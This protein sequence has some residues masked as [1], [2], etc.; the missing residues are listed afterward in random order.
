MVWTKFVTTV[1][2]CGVL[3]TVPAGAA[4]L[5]TT[6]RANF[7]TEVTC[8]ALRNAILTTLE[9]DAE[10]SIKQALVR[11][12]VAQ[13]EHTC[14]LADPDAKALV[15]AISNNDLAARRYGNTGSL[16]MTALRPPMPF[17]WYWLHNRGIGPMPSVRDAAELMGT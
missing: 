13:F 11:N 14:T 4:G 10:A 17:L 5:Y 16:P 7:S 3:L 8:L 6:Y 9:M 15:T 2:I 12:D 1:N